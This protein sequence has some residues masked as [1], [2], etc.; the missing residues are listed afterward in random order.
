MQVTATYNNAWKIAYPIMLGSLAQ[1]I[2][3]LT[4]T[5]FLARVSEVALGASAVAGVY[6]FVL[7]ML[8]MSLSIGAQILMSRKAGENDKAAIGNI[9]NHSVVTLFTLSVLLFLLM[10]YA[11]PLIFQKIL[12]SKEVADASIT[13]IYYR[14]FGIFF[15]LLINCFRAFYTSIS[16]TKFITYSSLVL[17][18]INILFAYCFIFGKFGFSEQG[19]AGAGKA[20]ALAEAVA[21]IFLL[22][23]TMVKK[24]IKSF[25][26]FR[27]KKMKFKII[28]NI[29]YIS[30]P[31][32]L[33]N[34]L[35]MGAWFL[36]FVFIEQLG[37]HALAISNIVRSAYMVLMTPI[38]GFAS[39]ANS[40]VSNLIGQ[41]KQQE[42]LRLIRKIVILSLSSMLVM[43]LLNLI[44]FR[45]LLKIMTSDSQLIV[46]AIP[47]Y[48]IIWCGMFFFS[49]SMVLLSAISGTGKTKIALYIEIFNIAVY[50]IFA[51]TT[52]VILKTKLEV[53]WST[54]IIYWFIMGLCAFIYLKSEKWKNDQV[55]I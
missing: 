7:V 32:F 14:S 20:S 36:F 12:K 45:F 41:Q 18:L 23:I 31:V 11:T 49:I 13:F 26:L 24:E 9:F 19:I 30:M 29:V 37:E 22:L 1:T 27:F 35:S 21:F 3:G 44:N 5:A 10:Q 28:Q 38:W 17:T 15:I 33:Q 34:L 4:D 48:I 2:L 25:G 47:S 54:E 52:A 46:D 50:I 53:V 51:Y 8:G 16:N 43:L 40:M 39:A 42:V 55:S 6:Y